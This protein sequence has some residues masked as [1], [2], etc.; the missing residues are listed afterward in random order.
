MKF[1]AAL[2]LI[3]LITALSV[4]PQAIEEKVEV[5]I[6]ES[7]SMHDSAMQMLIELHNHNDSLLI[8]KY[9]YNENP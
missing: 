4:K 8:Q 9:F 7:Q 2:G 3:V 1:L 5:Q 6:E